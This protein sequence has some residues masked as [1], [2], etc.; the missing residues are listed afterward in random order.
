MKPS[1]RSTSAT[2]AAWFEM[3]P[4]MFGKP[5]LKFEMQRIPTLW[6]LRPVSSAAR[7]GEH[8]GVTWKF[9]YCRPFAASRSMFGVSISEP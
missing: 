1:S 7:V 5:V 8:S 2:V 4:V 6:W 9:V 3:W